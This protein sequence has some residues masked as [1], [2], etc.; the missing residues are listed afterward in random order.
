[1]PVEREPQLRAFHLGLV[2]GRLPCA[3]LGRDYV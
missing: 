3:E 2:G 1:V